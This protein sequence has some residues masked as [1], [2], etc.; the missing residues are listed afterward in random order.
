MSAAEGNMYLWTAPDLLDYMLSQ[1]RRP[2]YSISPHHCVNLHGIYFI[3]LQEY[4]ED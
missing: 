4:H 3:H 2:Q 1:P